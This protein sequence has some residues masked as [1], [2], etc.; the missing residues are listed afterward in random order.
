MN[1]SQTQSMRNRLG[2]I[3]AIVFLTAALYDF[4]LVFY[5]ILGLPWPY[6][7]GYLWQLSRIIFMASGATSIVILA[8][9]LKPSK[10][11]WLLVCLTILWWISN[12]I[13]FFRHLFNGLLWDAAMSAGWY[14]VGGLASAVLLFSFY[15]RH[16]PPY[17]KPLL[18]L[19]ILYSIGLIMSQFASVLSWL[20]F[21]LTGRGIQLGDTFHSLADSF[22]YGSGLWVLF[23]GLPLLSFPVAVVVMT[24]AEKK[25]RGI[26]G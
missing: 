7:F 18:I 22:A 12:L 5:N 2:L 11:L 26:E 16:S 13:Y 10:L 1:E 25:K 14:I 15:R 20:G 23:A 17:K 3:S 21:Q 24:R 19:A 9:A 6:N 8:I 4:L